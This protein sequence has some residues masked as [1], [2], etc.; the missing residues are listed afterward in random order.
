MLVLKVDP[1]APEGYGTVKIMDANPRSAHFRQATFRLNEGERNSFVDGK[2]AI[3][4]LWR[5][6][7]KLGVLVTTS[8]KRAEALEAAHAVA[9][10][11]N[12]GGPQDHSAAQA[13]DAFMA[14]DF[15]RCIGLAGR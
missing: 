5:D 2:V 9:R 8:E 3:I 11:T 12:H 6:G 13:K 10:L 1:D 4:P 7:D 15:K 14:F